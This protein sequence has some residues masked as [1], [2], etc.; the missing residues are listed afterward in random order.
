MSSSDGGS[1]ATAL[2]AWGVCQK[3]LVRQF[4]LSTGLI[5]GAQMV[6]MV[7]TNLEI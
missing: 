2:G 5:A 4:I 3:G 6:Q 1:Y 7:L